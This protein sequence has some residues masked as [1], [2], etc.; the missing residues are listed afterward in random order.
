MEDFLGCY[1]SSAGGLANILDRG[2]ELDVNTIMT[3][4]S[5]PQRWNAQPFYEEIVQSYLKRKSEGTTVKK[6]F[7]HGIY[8]INLANPDKQKFHLSKLSVMNHLDLLNRIDGDG[9]VFHTGSIKDT[10]EEEG[11]KQI[12]SGLNW[13]F[14]NIPS[15]VRGRKLMLECAAGAGKIVGDKFEELKLI[16]KGVKDEFK[17]LLGFCLDTQHMFASG[18]DLIN[19]LE[20]I[21]QEIDDEL[22]IDKIVAI[23]FNDSKTELSSNR[24]RHENLGEGKIGEV[25]MKS[26]LNHPKLRNIPFIMETP[27]LGDLESA[28]EQ[29]RILKSW[30]GK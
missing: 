30:R 14:E 9:V 17:P 3:H 21:V 19:N 22:G 11:Y 8:L 20:Q 27:A 7:F 26:F 25:A 10:T 16:H 5:A 15:E 1:V 2:E 6:V 13:I 12:I 4:P 29:V 18:Y 28:K 23:H 24:D